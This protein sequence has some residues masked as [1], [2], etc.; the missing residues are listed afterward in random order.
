MNEQLNKIEQAKDI[1]SYIDILKAEMRVAEKVYNQYNSLPSLQEK[2]LHKL[3]IK[4][5]SITRFTERYNKLV[6]TL[7]L[8]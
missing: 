3:V 8:K 2:I 4:E 7:K 6:A 1:L 5:M